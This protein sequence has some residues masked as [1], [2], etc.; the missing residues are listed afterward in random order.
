MT[1]LLWGAFTHSLSTRWTDPNAQPNNPQA[2]NFPNN[3]VTSELIKTQISKKQATPAWHLLIARLGHTLATLVSPRQANELQQ[4][5]ANAVQLMA[6]IR[7]YSD[8]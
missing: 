3:Y 5:R 2:T 1:T 8:P 6:E 7:L 4:L